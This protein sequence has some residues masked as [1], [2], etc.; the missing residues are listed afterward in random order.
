M[1]YIIASRDLSLKDR[2]NFRQAGIQSGISRA[3]ALAIARQS[4][5]LVV[6]DLWPS[7]LGL[8]DWISFTDAADRWIN[9]TPLQPAVMVISKILCLSPE[10]HVS[11]MVFIR[12]PNVIAIHQLDGLYAEIPFWKMV[13]GQFVSPEAKEV[14]DRMTGPHQILPD[15]AGM[16]GYLS[17][18][19]IL[20]PMTLFQVTLSPA[21]FSDQIVIG[22]FMIERLGVNIA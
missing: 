2:S 12:G 8:K 21:R 4:S 6:R 13:A 9:V 3:L 11:R 15:C 5:E 22:G 7:D 14:L 16:E 10:P 17:E 20:E 19:I 1:S 18:P